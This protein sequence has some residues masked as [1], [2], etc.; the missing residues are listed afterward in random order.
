LEVYVLA[1]AENQNLYR[2]YYEVIQSNEAKQA[3]S[4]LIGWAASL[5]SHECFPSSHGVIKDFRFMRGTDW[6]FA[7]IPNQKWLLFYFRKPCLNIE[8]FSKS[9]ILERFPS[10]TENNAGEFTIRVSTLEIAA[11]ISAYIE[12]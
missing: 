11:Q 1:G 12:S 6:E 10:A 9:K 8:K 7:F 5:K 3:Y 4:Y 2:E